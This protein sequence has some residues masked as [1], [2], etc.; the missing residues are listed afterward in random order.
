MVCHVILHSLDPLL[1]SSMETHDV[2]STFGLTLL[3]GVEGLQDKVVCLA[4]EHRCESPFILVQ[5]YPDGS[6]AR[7]SGAD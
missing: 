4:W 1:L 2:A 6:D 3:E 7:Q 5:T